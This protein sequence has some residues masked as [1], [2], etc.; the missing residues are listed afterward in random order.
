MLAATA[1]DN[2]DFT[3]YAANKLS[4]A[5]RLD[6]A[7]AK[8]TAIENTYSKPELVCV[9]LSELYREKNKPDKA[10]A[11]A[12]KAYELGKDSDSI[13]PAFVYAKRLSEAGRFDEA[14]EILRFPHHKATYHEDVVSFWTDCMR[15]VIE[16]SIADRKFMQA[17][18]QCK[19]L[20]IIAPDDE[21]GKAKLEEVRE[22]LFPKKEQQEEADPAASL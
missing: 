7:E 1:N 8:Y 16:K 17:E 20:L 2:P 4:E 6:E 3:F 5:D 15:H 19:H 12:K 22:I 13:L 14:V 10:I 21:F 9:N 18:E 11:M